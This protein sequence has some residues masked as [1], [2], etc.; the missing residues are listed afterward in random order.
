MWR[1]LFYYIQSKEIQ[2]NTDYIM[3]VYLKKAIRV[4]IS[5]EHVCPG[6]SCAIMYDVIVQNNLLCLK[7]VY[8]KK[9]I[10]FL[11]HLFH[12]VERENCISFV[13]SP[14]MNYRFFAS[15]DEINVIFIP[16]N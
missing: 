1:N 2:G 14:L 8:N 9:E 7:I 15:P 11:Q 4:R 16:N 12:L 3:Y 6:W 5:C 13:A 10:K